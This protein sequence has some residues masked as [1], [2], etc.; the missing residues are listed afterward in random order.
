MKHDIRPGEFSQA[1]FPVSEATK[2]KRRA[3]KEVVKRV[4]ADLSKEEIELLH[5]YYRNTPIIQY[6]RGMPR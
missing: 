6:E 5:W 2:A 1:Y 3:S 4:T